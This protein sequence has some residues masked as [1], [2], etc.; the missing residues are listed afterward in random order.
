MKDRLENFHQILQM[1]DNGSDES[2]LVDDAM[3]LYEEMSS[4]NNFNEETEKFLIMAD[5]VQ[6][7][8]RA[9]QQL[10]LELRAKQSK[11][12]VQTHLDN[13]LEGDLDCLTK[14][15]KDL[16][17]SL[18]KEIKDLA[19]WSIDEDKAW[20]AEQRIRKCQVSA[21]QKVFQE[22]ICD[23]NKSQINH[24]DNCKKRIV[25]QLEIA[26]SV[27]SDEDVEEMLEQGDFAVFTV[28]IVVETQN[29][30]AALKLVESRH[31]DIIR[32]EKSLYEIQDLFLEMAR[33]IECQ[34]Q[35]ID[36]IQYNVES[37]DEYLRVTLPALKA[38]KKYKRRRMLLCCPCPCLQLCPLL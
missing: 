13:Q 6:Q 36:N 32:L 20:S 15:I 21:L 18:D 5:I 10:I 24:R 29:M 26:G 31:A 11:I 8:I 4:T 12:I 14:R 28:N 9:C 23:F 19:S 7:R 2:W 37:T 35:L 38:A 3:L 1:N 22:L 30:K 16:T 17:A 34:G 25:R 27:K 33:T